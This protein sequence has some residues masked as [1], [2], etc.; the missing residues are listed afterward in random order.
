MTAPTEPPAF[1]LAPPFVVLA[2]EFPPT[3]THTSAEA[4]EIASTFTSPDGRLPPTQL[5]PPS[6]V[7]TTE[8]LP[9]AA[10]NVVDGHEIEVGVVP[11]GSCSSDQLA[12]PSVVATT[13]SGDP[14]GMA[15]Q[16]AGL[17]Q[18]MAVKAA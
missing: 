3:A 14:R 8:V 11:A 18:E 17:G 6:D 10:Q 5:A 15:K 13:V 16:S 12:P 4:H 1:Q 7:V 2:I 9:T